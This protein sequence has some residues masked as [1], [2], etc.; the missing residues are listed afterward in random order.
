MKVYT[1]PLNRND[2]FVFYKQDNI[3]V[4]VNDNDYILP[5]TSSL[6]NKTDG[7]IKKGPPYYD[8]VSVPCY[9]VLPEDKDCFLKENVLACVQASESILREDDN[10]DK[11]NCFIPYKIIEDDTIELGVCTHNAIGKFEDKELT[12]Y[13]ERQFKMKAFW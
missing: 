13:I 7:F 3:L 4:C 9:R 1:I 5:I 10:R 12:K 6:W 11:Y 8:R 2:M